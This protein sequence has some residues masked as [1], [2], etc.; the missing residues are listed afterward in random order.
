MT[1]IPS[2]LPTNCIFGKVA[3]NFTLEEVAVHHRGICARVHF[4]SISTSGV[5]RSRLGLD[6]QRRGERGD[7]CCEVWF[8]EEWDATG[9]S[10]AVVSAITSS[11][12][13]AFFMVWEG[14][15]KRGC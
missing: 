2:R 8:E 9:Q 14:E 15:C 3:R 13:T 1:S 11:T 7:A 4:P 5:T 12:T 10:R 6:A